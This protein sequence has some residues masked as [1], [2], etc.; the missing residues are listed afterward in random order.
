MDS[1]LYGHAYAKSPIDIACWDILGQAAGL[2]VSD[3]LGGTVQPRFPL[4]NVVGRGPAG[5]DAR[6]R[7]DS[8]LKLGLRAGSR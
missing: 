5:E 8:S 2:P 3:L 1:V 6:A 4:Y 7:R